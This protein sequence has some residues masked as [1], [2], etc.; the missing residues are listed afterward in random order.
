LNAL[1]EN[2]LYARIDMLDTATG[3]AIIEVELIEPSLYFNMDEESP[4]RFAQAIAKR[5]K[6]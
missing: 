6:S 3:L 5:A 2:A 1:P 4:K